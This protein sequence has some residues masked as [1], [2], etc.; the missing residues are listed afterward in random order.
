MTERLPEAAGGVS[1][2]AEVAAGV[3]VGQFAYVGPGV[4]VETECA[5][6]ARATVAALRDGERAPHIRRGARIGAGAVVI[7]VVEIG[8]E[9]VVRPGAVVTRDIPPRAIVAGS[10]AQIIGE[11]GTVR[12]GVA[13]PVEAPTGAGKSVEVALGSLIRLPHVSDS[14]GTLVFGELGAGL[15]FAAR[16]FFVN[17]DVPTESLRGSH[18]HRTLHEVLVAVRGSVTVS[19]DDGFAQAEVVLDDPTKALYLP[20]M[21]WSSQYAYTAG[22]ALLVL[23]SDE[24]DDGDYIRDYGE[25]LALV[26]D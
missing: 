3:P 16:R 26:R 11:S 25:Y 24:Y 15:P 1:P 20:P 6:G 14:R 10:P 13:P 18:A 22:A 2:L 21:V 5:I 9:A 7:G 8:A 12:A 19:V 17:Y 4:V 23:C